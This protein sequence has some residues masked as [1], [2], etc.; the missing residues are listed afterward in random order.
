[1]QGLERLKSIRPKQCKVCE[2]E[3]VPR[4]TTAQVCGFECAVA[5][6]AKK[7]TNDA[8]R[9][10]K[11]A[12]VDLR[13][14]I[15]KAKPLSWHKAKAQ[16]AFNRFICLRDKLAG[17][18]CISCGTNK[19]EIQYCA[20]HYRT[21]GA[22]PQLAL[23]EDNVHRQCNKRCN[24]ELSGNIRAY[25]PALIERIGQERFDAIENNH[26]TKRW[27]I[28][29]LEEIGRMYRMKARELIK[30]SNGNGQ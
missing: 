20:G 18:G 21:R 15:V 9:I 27:T 23:N 13:K 14:E 5:W 16:A 29:D 2:R 3:F 4:S 1:M 7:N 12:R 17:H 10:A 6:S 30:E 26:E 11:A 24:C 22:A 8:A 19:P 25:T 28:P